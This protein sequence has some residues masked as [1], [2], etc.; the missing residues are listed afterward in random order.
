M[1]RLKK[2]GAVAAMCAVFITGFEGTRQ[3]AYQD[4]VG[5]WTVCTGETEGVHRGDH[6]SLAEC[7]WKLQTRLEDYANPIEKCLPGLNDNQFIAFTSLAYNIGAERTCRSTAANLM[8]SKQPVAA[9]LAFMSWNRA[10]GIVFP[11][12]TRRRAAERDLCLKA[13]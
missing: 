1:S 11:G 6:Y 7:K 10:G 5:V 3:N 9:C 13:A 12:L 4:V 2:G 8:R